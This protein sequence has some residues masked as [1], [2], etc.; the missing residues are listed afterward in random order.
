MSKPTSMLTMLIF[1]A[2][3][4]IGAAPQALAISAEALQ[5]G[6]PSLAPMLERVTPAVVNIR[7]T[8]AMPTASRFF[9]DGEQMPDEVRRY[10][11]NLPEINRNNRQR[12]FAT[13]AGSGVIVDAELGYVITNHHV[14]GGAANISV[15]LSDGRTLEAQLLG[16]DEST[17]VA[18]LQIPAEDLTD[19]QYADISTVQ[20]GDYVVAI[21]NPYGI[22]QTVT[23]GI[24]S[25]L[26][27]AGLNNNNYEDFIQT[28][29]SI[30]VGNSGG[31]LVD[32]EG[33]LI[34]INSAIISGSGGSNG[35]G[36][37]VPVD[38]V[39]VVTGHLQRD[40]E[41]R[42]GMLGVTIT[43]VTPDMIA[44]LDVGVESGALVTSV[45]AGSAAERAGV[46]ISDVIVEIEGR[47]ITSSRELRNYVGLMRQDQ[48]VDLVV[49]RDGERLELEAVIGGAEGQSLEG[50]N[51]PV[52]NSEFRGAQLRSLQPGDSE[53]A[54]SGVQVTQV[55]PQSRSWVAG[56][57]EGDVII[58][59][60]R[61]AVADLAGFNSALQDAE[62]FMALTLLREGQR[63]LIFAR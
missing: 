26:G 55:Q 59:L 12:P 38:M 19:I 6:I 18:L 52:I 21:G 46:E 47:G 61:Q 39:A 24:V 48:Q 27:R 57:R 7:V 15:Q 41:V 63:L 31:A 4:L 22:G 2:L 36:F 62:R 43:S 37:A 51:R 28:D 44:A 40:G 23:S 35:I 58:E 17:D 25:A 50:G 20:V 5:Q 34:G 32:L 13:G 53:Y 60:N 49:F 16:S 42:R 10:F 8:K 54:D 11:E 56:L 45:L 1:G 9:L 29:A 30:N 14:V 33:R 3:M